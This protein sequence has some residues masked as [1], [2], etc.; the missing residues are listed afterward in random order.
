MNT[1]KAKVRDQAW[2]R[3]TAKKITGWVAWG[4]LREIARYLLLTHWG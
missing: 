4:M 1:I 2:R 3:E